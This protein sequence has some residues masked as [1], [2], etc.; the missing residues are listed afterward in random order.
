M[1][2]Y[3]E[4]TYGERIAEVYDLLYGKRDN[5]ETVADFLAPLAGKRRALELGIG[6]GRIAIAL[7]ARGVRVTGIDA[8]PAMVAKMRAKPG[9]ADIPVVMGNFADVKVTGGFGLVYVAFSTLFALPDQDEQ[10][11]CFQRVA[12][13]ILPAGAFVVEAFNPDHSLLAQRQRVAAVDVGTDHALLDSV[14]N[15]V[16]NQTVRAQHILFTAGGVQLYPLQLRFAYPSELDLMARLAGMR[17]RERYGGWDRSLFT[18]ASP[19]HIS[20]Y[21][22]EPKA[23][24]LSPKITSKRKP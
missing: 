12:K 21:E 6:T 18:A 15:D 8:S 9:G 4:T 13:R 2:E 19:V 14:T 10:V 7:A 3:D 1:A 20:V 16:V 11:R 22:L 17:L 5:P 23:G 24:S